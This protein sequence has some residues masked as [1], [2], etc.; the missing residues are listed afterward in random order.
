MKL[1]DSIFWKNTALK[2]PNKECH[3]P[4]DSKRIKS[5]AIESWPPTHSKKF[6]AEIKNKVLI[7]KKKKKHNLK[8]DSYVLFGRHS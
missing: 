5:L 1:Y 4:S 3:S 8:V 6:R 7:G 2:L